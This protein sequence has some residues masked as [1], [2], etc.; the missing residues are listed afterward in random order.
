MPPIANNWPDK[1][2]VVGDVKVVYD[3][4]GVGLSAGKL[5]I[6]TSW[7]VKAHR[8]D[9]AYYDY[10]TFNNLGG[11]ERQV[12]ELVF[13]GMYGLFPVGIRTNQ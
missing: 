3:E 9:A 8:N 1:S 12:M 11:V 6:N 13:S 7:Y 2:T 4:P 5:R 10:L